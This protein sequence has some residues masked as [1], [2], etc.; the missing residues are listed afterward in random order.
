MKGRHKEKGLGKADIF[1][2][3]SVEKTAFELNLIDQ[4]TENSKCTE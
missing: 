4:K 3:S 2:Q 1:T